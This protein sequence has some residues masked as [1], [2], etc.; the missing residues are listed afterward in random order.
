[1]ATSFIL[2]AWFSAHIEL[3]IDDWLK[4][5]FFSSKQPEQPD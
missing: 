2:A 1:M 4:Q 5:R 3:H